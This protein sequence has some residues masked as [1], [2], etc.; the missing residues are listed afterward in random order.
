M[1]DGPAVSTLLTMTG[2]WETYRHELDGVEEEVRKNLNSHVDLVNTVAAHILNSG[3]KRVRPLLLLLC[4]RLLGYT[5][6]DH[7]LLGCLIEYIHT[8]T[9]LHDDVVD[10]AELR[11]GTP[12]ARKMWGNQISILVGDYLYSKAMCQIVEFRNQDLNEILSTACRKM[13]EGELLQLY[14]NGNP[15]LTESELFRI[16]EHKTATLIAASCRMGGIISGAS[17]EQQASLSQFG[18][19]L[20]I[21]FQLADDTLDYEANGNRLGKSLGQDLREGKVTLPLLHLQHHCSDED[22]KLIKDRMETRAFSEA[23]L[24]RILSLMKHYGS[25]TYAKNRARAFVEAARN[26]LAAFEESPAKRALVVVAE[27]MVNR[28][29]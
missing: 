19:H 6:H 5:T 24:I 14:Y 28:D 20:G 11:R 15:R 10:E 22:R 13:A 12:T 8:A 1:N 26:D 23:D 17:P 21:A 2:I 4:G 16:V 29:H 9:L 18:Q 7:L 27:Y 25:L 3:G